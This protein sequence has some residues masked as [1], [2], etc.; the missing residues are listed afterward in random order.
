MKKTAAEAAQTRERVLDAAL[1]EFAER[2]WE[3]A[4]FERIGVRAGSTRGAVHH[5]FPGGKEQLLH[6]VLAEQWRRYGEPVL[7]PL[8]RPGPGGER[9]TRFLRGYLD[10]LADDE[11]FRALATVT[12]LVAP[13][14]ETRQEDLREH[15]SALDAWRA[16]VRDVVIASGV[17]PADVSPDT[18]VFVVLNF[19]VGLTTM[20]A[21]EPD[22]LPA[23]PTARQAVVTATLAGLVEA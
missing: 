3:K 14:A 10:L 2:G 17:L 12:T 20:V 5:H 15:G 7:A 9:L 22:R 16:T 23:T 11:G 21:L 4:T 13:R 18:A 6:A 1:L 8:H 19:L